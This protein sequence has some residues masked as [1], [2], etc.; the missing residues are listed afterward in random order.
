MF[1]TTQQ[2]TQGN[3]REKRDTVRDRRAF[4]KDVGCLTAG[5]VMSDGLVGAT[6]RSLQSGG[7]GS[8]RQVVIGGRRVKTIDVHT[9]CYVLE[10]MP[11]VEGHE[12]GSL[13]RAA[14]AKTRGIRLTPDVIG[15]ERVQWMDEHGIDV[16]VLSINPYWHTAERELATRLIAVQNEALAA[17]CAKFPG[18]FVG[19]A[20]VAMQHPDLAA[21]QLEDAM[22]MGMPGAA[23][24]CNVAGDELANPRFDPFWVKVEELSALIFIHPQPEGRFNGKRYPAGMDERL[25]GYGNLGNTI[26]NPLETTIA[27][28]HLIF[29]GTLDKFPGL[30][31]CGGHGGGFLPSYVGRSDAS[32]EWIARGCKPLKKKPSEY[33]KEQLLCDSLVFNSEELRL[34]VAQYGVGQVVLG[35]DHPAPWPVRGVDHVL[36]TAS[37]SDTDKIAILGGNLSKLLRIPQF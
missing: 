6:A 11:L 23:L 8:R 33:F 34:R 10:V 25:S 14:A 28:S 2:T 19:F 20:S 4:I 16:Q 27:F 17:A 37:L 31:I 1:G 18:R 22:K 7:A 15:P 3:E 9:H 21:R 35:T 13:V 24:A 29:E 32:C 12:W 30:R 36:E 26:G 5:I